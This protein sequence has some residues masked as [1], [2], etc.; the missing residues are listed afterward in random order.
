MLE[1]R[2]NYWNGEKV[3]GQIGHENFNRHIT[4]YVLGKPTK[5]MVKFRNIS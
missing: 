3:I 1:A 4:K 2:I 5:N